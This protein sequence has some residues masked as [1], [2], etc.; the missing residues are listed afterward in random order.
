MVRRY[1]ADTVV[2]AGY[3][4]PNRGLA[5]ALVGAPFGVHLAGNVNGTSSIQ[6]AIHSAA[7]VARVL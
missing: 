1:R 2:I 5:D 3:H 4:E 6:A 7:T